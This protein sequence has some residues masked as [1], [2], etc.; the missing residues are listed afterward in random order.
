MSKKAYINIDY[1]GL[2][3]PHFSVIRRSKDIEEPY[4][5]NREDLRNELK[6]TSQYKKILFYD[7]WK[8]WQKV[9]RSNSK[10]NVTQKIQSAVKAPISLRGYKK[11]K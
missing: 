10:C 6:K 2:K 9:Y 1:I 3:I 11:L 4:S 5:P 7:N 8:G